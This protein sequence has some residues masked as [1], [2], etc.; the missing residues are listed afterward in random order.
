MVQTS[1]F[2]TMGKW[3]EARIGNICLRQQGYLF[4]L[5]D[6]RQEIRKRNLHL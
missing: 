5:V 2:R 1:I 6:V 3:S 4:W